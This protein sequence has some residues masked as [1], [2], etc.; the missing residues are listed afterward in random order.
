MEIVRRAL[1]VLSVCGF[2][3]SLA[4]YLFSYDGLTLDRMGW[5]PFALTLGIFL[6]YGPMCLI[7]YSSMSQRTFW[8]GFGA[9]KPFW[10][11][12]LLKWLGAFF[13][14]HFVLFG[15][16]SHFA[17][18]DIINGRYVLNDHGA[19]KKVLT[20]REYV[21]LKGDELRIFPTGWMVFYLGMAA[22][23]WFPRRRSGGA[24]EANRD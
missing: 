19:I 8:K 13:A 7:E 11:V 12:P 22:Y 20:Q 15:V 23:W 18:P 5:W 16:L 6:L 4:V 3:A 1:A 17:A 2:A 21:S 10:V 14:I 9:G 24:L